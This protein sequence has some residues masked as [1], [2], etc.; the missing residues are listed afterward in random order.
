GP[1]QP[2]KAAAASRCPETEVAQP[3]PGGKQRGEDLATPEPGLGPEQVGH[4]GVQDP[5]GEDHL[6]G[7]RR[8]RSDTVEDEFATGKQEEQDGCRPVA[9]PRRPGPPWLVADQ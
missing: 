2:S 6:R 7:P 1:R 9:E 5:V 8:G 4:D 3:T